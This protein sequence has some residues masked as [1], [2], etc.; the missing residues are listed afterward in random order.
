MPD[1]LV[2]AYADVLKAKRVLTADAHWT[3][4]S[5]RVELVGT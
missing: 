1:A 3:G 5:R 4:R 2:L